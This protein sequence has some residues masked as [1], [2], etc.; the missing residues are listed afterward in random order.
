M[1]CDP[2]GG[3]LAA[4]RSLEA[5]QA[6]GAWRQAPC[7]SRPQSIC[8]TTGRRA[9]VLAW[10]GGSLD[11][12]LGVRVALDGGERFVAELAQD[13]VGAAAE[14]AGNGEAGAVVV[15]PLGDLQVVAV[16]GR[17]GAGRLLCRLEQR[18]AQHLGPFLRELAGR[19]LAVR[20]VDGDVEAGVADGVVG[21]SEAARGSRAGGGR[22]SAAPGRAAP[23][24]GRSSRSFA[25]PARQAPARPGKAPP[26]RAPPGRRGC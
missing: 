4:A 20:L 6:V 24:P 17:A 14:L 3:L 25:A 10:L 16:V 13:V 2:R 26:A 21:A 12:L 19:A 15:D 18:P 11:R 22:T 9:R 1:G 5:V 7:G 23:A 8:V